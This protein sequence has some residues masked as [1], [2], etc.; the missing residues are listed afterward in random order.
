MT[1][2]V[3]YD[4]GAGETIC[5]ECGLVFEAYSIDD[6]PEWSTFSSNRVGFA[7]NTLSGHNH[8][9]TFISL[10]SKSSNSGLGVSRWH[11]SVGSKNPDKNLIHGF[12]GIVAMSDRLNHV[13]TIKDRANEIFKMVEDHKIMKG[14]K[15]KQNVQAIYAACL[16]IACEEHEPGSF[17]EFTIVANGAAKK[18]ISR[19]KDHKKEMGEN[20]EVGGA[21]ATDFVAWFC[22]HPSLEFQTV[23]FVKD[24][25]KKSEELDIRSRPTTVAA[26]VIYMLPQ[27]SQDEKKRLQEITDATEVTVTPSGMHTKTSIHI[28]C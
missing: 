24:A 8:V 20:I 3:V 6:T 9:S 7:S 4:H 18:E 27:L 13:S 17:K 2:Q 5:L 11:N 12:E 23:K 21:H 1:T 28:H 10:P 22:S 14:T 16:S 26:T 19:A 25:L 15:T